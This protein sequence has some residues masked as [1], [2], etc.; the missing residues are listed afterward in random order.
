VF[1]LFV[2]RPTPVCRASRSNSAA[3]SGEGALDQAA[4]R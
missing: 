2:M 4:P 3:I 1:G